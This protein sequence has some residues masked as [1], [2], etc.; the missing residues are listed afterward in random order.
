MKKNSRKTVR[1]LG[2]SPTSRGIGFAVL[3][4]PQRLADWGVKTGAKTDFANV[5]AKI[6]HLID[7]YQ[8]EA[9]AIRDCASSDARCSKRTRALISEIGTLAAS[10]SIPVKEVTRAQVKTALSTDQ[11]AT[12]HAIARSIAQN[13]SQELGSRLPSK[14][15]PWTSEDYR[16]C[17]FEAV[18]LALALIPGA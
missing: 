1:I 16:M 15:R 2:L 3:E 13:F 11:D 14:R 7:H 6:A 10:R 8:P 17:I 18:A 4:G 12:K 5:L 9:I